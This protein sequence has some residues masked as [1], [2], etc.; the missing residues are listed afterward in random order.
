MSYSMVKVRS[1][2][3]SELYY[4]EIQNIV[5][6]KNAPIEMDIIE[7]VAKE[8][9]DDICERF[10]QKTKELGKVYR[11][12]GLPKGAEI[13]GDKKETLFHVIK[14]RLTTYC[15]IK[16]LGVKGNREQ[17]FIFE[18]YLGDYNITLGQKKFVVRISNEPLHVLTRTS[19]R[20]GFSCEEVYNGY[21]TGPFHDI[22]LRNPTV[23]LLDNDG[24]FYGRLNVRWTGNPKESDIGIDPNI[25][26]MTYKYQDA[27]NMLMGDRRML[28]LVLFTL[29]ASNGYGWYNTETT[30]YIYR[31]HSDTTPS[32][33]V[34][35]P[36]RGLFH[37]DNEDIQ[38]YVGDL[39]QIEFLK[40]N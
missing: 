12:S 2:T 28:H 16:R 17:G 27:R 26:P 33:H 25:Y 5:K 24:N 7:K 4:P 9:V 10:K 29:F 20:E 38:N 21:W 14:H 15:K 35:L 34:R 39:L 19:G 1:H 23:Y 3:D 22:A 18:D 37:S 8:W 32:G 30:P 11:E 40:L 13:T 6:N 36:F 31:G